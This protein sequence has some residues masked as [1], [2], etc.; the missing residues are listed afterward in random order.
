MR[1]KALLFTYNVCVHLVLKSTQI[2]FHC[3]EQCY[4][5][6]CPLVQFLNISKVKLKERA[7]KPHSSTFGHIPT[8]TLS[9][10]TYQTHGE[11]VKELSSQTL[12]TKGIFYFFFPCW[13]S[14]FLFWFNSSC[15]WTGG[16]R[17]IQL[18]LKS[19]GWEFFLQVVWFFR[20]GV[21]TIIT[22]QEKTQGVGPGVTMK[23]K[24][25]QVMG[26]IPVEQSA[27]DHP[28]F[29]RC[30]VKTTTPLTYR[31]LFVVLLLSSLI[32]KLLRCK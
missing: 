19:T 27:R 23:T 24:S 30:S 29:I 31:E 18:G 3:S 7:P 25:V 17:R 1:I 22:K 6:N 28:C 12:N 11:P 15:L 2:F 20:S 32:V 26:E 4:R 14:S 16:D 5:Q 10:G 21:R 9:S 8:L 13:L